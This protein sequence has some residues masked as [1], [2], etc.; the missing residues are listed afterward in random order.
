MNRWT[1]SGAHCRVEAFAGGRRQVRIPDEEGPHAGADGGAAGEAAVVAHPSGA[2]APDEFPWRVRVPR[3]RASAGDTP[4]RCRRGESGALEPDDCQVQGARQAEEAQAGLGHP[5][6]THF[7]SRRLGVPLWRQAQGTGCGDEPAGCRRS[8]AE[9]AAA[10]ATSTLSRRSGAASARAFDVSRK[11]GQSAGLG[12]PKH[13]CAFEAV[14]APPPH[15]Q[16][17]TGR[18]LPPHALP[19]S[20]AP[21]HRVSRFDLLGRV[22]VKTGSAVPRSRSS[23]F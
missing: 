8:A 14:F 15:S 9:H 19:T 5:S 18:R 6:A 11:P 22:G 16:M 7:R 23:K 20:S 21:Q 2:H 17:R 10:G 3:N 4:R 12:K 1:S 13:T